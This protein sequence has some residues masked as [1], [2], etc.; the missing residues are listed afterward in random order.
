MATVINREIAMAGKITFAR[1]MEQALGHPEH[2]YYARANLLWGRRGDF[3]TSPE[4]HPIFGYLWGRQIEECWQLLD[5]PQ[6]FD[7][8][9]L[10]GGSGA[11]AVSIL[12]WLRERAPTCYAAA[13]VQLIEGHPQRLREQREVLQTREH[14]A[15][16]ILM[17]EWLNREAPVYG[18]AISNELFDAFPVHLVERRGKEL[19]E[20]Y[21][22][23]AS[24]EGLDFEIGEASIPALSQ[25]FEKLGLEPGDGCRAEVPLAAVK[26]MRQLAARFERGYM[27]TIDYGYEAEW[28]YAPWRRMGTLMAFRAHSPQPN[29]L[30]LPGL[31]DLTSH[32][33]LTSLTLAAKCEGFETTQSVSQSE[34]LI[35]LGIGKQLEAT[36][37]RAELDVA[38]FIEAR[39][40]VETL[41]EPAGL[42]RI[43]VLAQAKGAQLKGLRCLIDP[44]SPSPRKT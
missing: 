5:R 35:A 38:G 30:M 2:G 25:Y 32:T 13:K 1:F 7:L 28:L 23:N 40:A 41:I 44:T 39:R 11:F 29:P 8:M 37:E 21:V 12:D 10:G 3:E 33:D 18:V 20:W 9:E 27:I 34:A 4:V 17:G 14:E 26:T 6:S 43:R 22:V 36:R 15:E 16:Y 24:E 19:R 42:G 31:T